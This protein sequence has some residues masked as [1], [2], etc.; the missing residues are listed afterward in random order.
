[1]ASRK[2]LNAKNLEALGAPR[3]AQLLL[4]VTTGNAEQ[5]RHLRLALAAAQGV[6]DLVGEVN[7]RLSALKRSR[8]FVDWKGRKTLLRDLE[9]QRAAI[10][11]I[12]K[13]DAREALE[14]M[15]RF[16]E[17]APSVHERCDDGSGTI[18]QVFRDGCED[19]GQLADSANPDPVLLGNR[20]LAAILDNGYGQYDGLIFNLASALGSVGLEHLKTQLT[21]LDSKPGPKHGREEVFERFDHKALTVR[22]ALQEI[23]DLQGDVEAYCDQFEPNQRKFPRIAAG[24]ARRLLTHNRCEEAL[25]I[26]DEVEHRDKGTNDIGW[27]TYDWEDARIDTLEALGRSEE[28]QAM[29]RACF[30]DGL[31]A[32]HLRAYLKQLRDFEDFEAEA[33]ALDRVQ[34]HESV[35]QALAFLVNW[36][37]LDRAADLVVNRADELDGDH[38]EVLSPTAEALCAKHPLAA[39]L[40]LRAMISFTLGKAR[41]TRYGHAAR[42]LTECE[43][44]AHSI[45]D[46]GTFADH[47]AYVNQLQET[48]SRKSGFWSRMR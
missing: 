14:L 36:P 42:H 41:S 17:L 26:L 38:Y 44:L 24:I 11:E 12:A 6:G 28:A 46:F 39:T 47:D 21:E 23:A 30:D 1:M 31:S 35:L 32:D 18:G 2:T 34:S 22:I 25:Q 20:M 33:N 43:S 9:S 29:R 45:E 5:K 19:L 16:I 48:H 10:L 8:A 27:R 7:R 3:L 13:T 15:W 40:C 4:E 37:A